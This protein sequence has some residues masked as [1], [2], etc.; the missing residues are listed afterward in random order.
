MSNVIS[1]QC[2]ITIGL[3]IF[4]PFEDW[5]IDIVLEWVFLCREGMFCVL[6]PYIILLKSLLV[7]TRLGILFLVKVCQINMRDDVIYRQLM[8]NFE[9]KMYNANK[10]FFLSCQNIFLHILFLPGN[11]LQEERIPF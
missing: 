4:V 10:F 8:R 1:F 7:N 11:K 9:K 3:F 5:L 2:S 6:M